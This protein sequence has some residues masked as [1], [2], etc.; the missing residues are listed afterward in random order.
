MK[1]IAILVLALVVVLAAG[2]PASGQAKPQTPPPS[3][4]P[5]ST[6]PAAQ[7][8][9]P[10]PQKPAAQAPRR[11]APS[12][13]G[14]LSVTVFVTDRSGKPLSGVRVEVS[15]PTVREGVTNPQGSVKLDRLRAGEYRMHLE[16]EGFVALEKELNLRATDEIE[17]TLTPAPQPPQP[18]PPSTEPKPGAQ[19]T[20][21]TGAGRAPADPNATVE[22]VSVVDWL[23]KNRLERGEPRKELVVAGVPGEAASVLQVRDALRDRAHP[24]A[25]EVIYVINGSAT[26]TSKGRVRA[27]E[28][29]SLLLIPRGVTFSIENRG[30]EPLWALSVL[31]PGESSSR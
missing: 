22:V 18:P 16:A 2:R 30:R 14:R 6:P 3:S 7:Q 28:T 13:V 9:A 17:V 12:T 8:P 4:P 10:A 19:P 20:A 21:G 1:R 31:A 25:D 24:D 29:G 26:L 11:A 23:A 5:A 15:G 27:I